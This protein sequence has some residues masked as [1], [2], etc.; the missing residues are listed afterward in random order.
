MD[1][2]HGG[3]QFQVV[4]HLFPRMPRHRL[5]YIRDTYLEPFCKKYGY[6]YVL[7]DF[8]TANG[9]VLSNLRD[10]AVKARKLQL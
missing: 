9:L 7:R 2:F 10:M 8:W 5:R 1:W 6:E 3:L 4:H